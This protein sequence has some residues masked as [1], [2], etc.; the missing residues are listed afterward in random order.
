MIKNWS[1]AEKI[2]ESFY[3]E[4]LDELLKTTKNLQYAGEWRFDLSSLNLAH[5][6]LVKKSTNKPLIF[7]CRKTA[8]SSE[9][10]YQ[11]YKLAIAIGFEYIDMDFE[12]DQALLLSLKEEI[13]KSSI[14]LILSYHNYTSTPEPAKLS[15][16]INKT[17]SFNSAHKKIVCLANDHTDLNTLIRIQKQNKNTICFAMGK[18][19]TTSRINSL[20]N[21][22]PFAYIAYNS[23]QKT[24]EGQLSFEEFAQAYQQELAKKPMRLA[25]LGNPI[26]HSKSPAIFKD[27]FQ[28]HNIDGAY[29]KIELSS[30]NDF[31]TLQEYHGFNI[32]A[33]FKQSII[34]FLHAVSDA[35][36]NIGAV[37][38]VYKK[39]GEYYG[40]NTDYLGIIQ[41][42]KQALPLEKIEGKKVLIIGAGGAARAA[43]YAA[44][45]LKCSVSII[46]RTPKKAQELSQL[47]KIDF[48]TK[49]QIDLKDFSIIINTVPRVFNLINPQQLNP[50]HLVLDAVYPQS[51]FSELEIEKAIRLIPGEQWLWY[52][53]VASF[54]LFVQYGVGKK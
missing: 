8:A 37:N 2:V 25:V 48:F 50:H 29:E 14:Q 52:Q 44:L 7:T 43:I 53:A 20:L 18:Y 45:Q 23:Y 10:Q 35:V 22:A 3:G 1:T 6:S 46:N 5:I 19:A 28:Q 4:T 39:D 40:D 51:A 24:A 36:K 17:A 9:I 16:W 38:T 27:F 54:N 32:T 31:D 13:S 34:P 15:D 49:E 21:G 12:E 41:C 42:L 26:S 33:P 47:F 30:I 11:A